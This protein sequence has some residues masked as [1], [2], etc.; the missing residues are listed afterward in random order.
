MAQLLYAAIIFFQKLDFMAMV[1]KKRGFSD[2]AL[3]LAAG[4]QISVVQHQDPHCILNP[5]RCRT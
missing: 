1:T 4:D 2:A 3:I 5:A